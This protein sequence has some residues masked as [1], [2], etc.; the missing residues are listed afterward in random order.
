MIPASELK[1]GT[2]QEQ[3]GTF[4]RPYLFLFSIS[5]KHPFLRLTGEWQ[6]FE[7]LSKKIITF[8]R[9]TFLEHMK[10]AHENLVL[11]TLFI[12]VQHTFQ[13]NI[14]ILML[15]QIPQSKIN[16]NVKYLNILYLVMVVS[17][18]LFSR[19]EIYK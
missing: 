9:L 6:L 3:F 14:H 18:K 15:L 19:L 13:T 11:T 8:K 1:K 7:H 10:N 4:I 16:L 12:I 17:F 5:Q 2:F